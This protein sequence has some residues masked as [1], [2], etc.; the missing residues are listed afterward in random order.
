MILYLTGKS[1]KATADEM[2]TE[3]SLDKNN[4]QIYAL[5]W[6]SLLNLNIASRLDFGGFLAA[7]CNT[8]L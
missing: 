7:K 6:I 3:P 1:G 2:T 5:V 4:I 8:W